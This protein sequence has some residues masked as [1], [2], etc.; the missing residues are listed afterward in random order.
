LDRTGTEERVT[1]TPIVCL[2]HVA[3][4]SGAG[5]PCR[6]MARFARHRGVYVLE[7]RPEPS[8]LPLLGSARTGDVT[9]LTRYL[10]AEVGR[11]EEPRVLA[12]LLDALLESEGVELPILWV[13]DAQAL[14]MTRRLRTSAVV[15]DCPWGLEYE[16]DRARAAAESALLDVADLVLVHGARDAT[17]LRGRHPLVHVL[18]DDG[19]QLS[20]AS[21]TSVVRL[22]DDLLHTLVAARARTL[23]AG[24]PVRAARPRAAARSPFLP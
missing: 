2:S 5:H 20:A 4:S 10:P 16:H 12:P 11:D 18:P 17:R 15:Y 24:V 1:S 3:W 21:D 6:L 7:A 22:L 9:V 13:C 23:P 14:P 19:P 8:R